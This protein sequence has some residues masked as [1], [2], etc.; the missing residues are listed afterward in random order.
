LFRLFTQEVHFG[1]QLPDF[2]VQLFA[3]TLEI[4]GFDIYPAG[5]RRR[6]WPPLSWLASNR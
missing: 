4:L 2:G 1:G 3:L 5:G 6:R